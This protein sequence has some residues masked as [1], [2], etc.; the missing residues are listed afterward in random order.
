MAIAER[1]P[2]KD[3]RGRATGLPEERMRLYAETALEGERQALVHMSADS[4]RNWG[5]FLHAAGLANIFTMVFRRSAGWTIGSLR[6]APGMA[7][8][9]RNKYGGGADAARL[10]W[11]R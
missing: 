10:T 6:P 7:Q 3:E 9:I 11:T 4:G 5:L 2:T 1:V 8:W